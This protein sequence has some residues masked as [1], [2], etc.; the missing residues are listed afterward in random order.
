MHGVL[1]ALL[2]VN[3]VLVVLNVRGWFRTKR[4]A[5]L[6]ASLGSVLLAG[7]CLLV[8]SVTP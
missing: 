8:L 2:V 1:R 7:G 5:F 4:T 6:C 3:L